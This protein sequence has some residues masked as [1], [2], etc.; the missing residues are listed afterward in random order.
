[1]SCMKPA[2]RMVA[3]KRLPAPRRGKS[4]RRRVRVGIADVKHFV[5]LYEFADV[6]RNAA[7][8]AIVARHK[9]VVVA[10][11]QVE[12]DHPGGL[13]EHVFRLRP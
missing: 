3:A 12:V 10:A 5:V 2:N 1:M 4:G 6:L 9:V 11:S 7:L 13:A 8:E